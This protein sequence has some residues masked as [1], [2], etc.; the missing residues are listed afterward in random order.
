MRNVALFEETTFRV[1]LKHGVSISWAFTRNT[2]MNKLLQRQIRTILGQDFA[3]DEKMR[4]FLNS[5][6]ETYEFYEDDRKLLE[7][8]MEISSME[9]TEANETLRAQS[10]HQQQ[11]LDRIKNTI[12][13]IR[14]EQLHQKDLE[15]Y[16]SD[17][18][19]DL[20]DFLH[21]LVSELKRN[22]ALLRTKEQ[23]MNEAQRMAQFG[24]WNYNYQTGELKWSLQ[25]FSMMGRDPKLGVPS[26]ENAFSSLYG[27]SDELFKLKIERAR[28]AGESSF[29]HRI[30]RADGNIRWFESHL[31]MEKDEDN[32]PVALF[33]TSVDITD[34]VHAQQKLS[35]KI[36]E[37]EE[38]NRSLDTIIDTLPIM[39]FIKEA[40]SRQFIR[41]NDEACQFYGL[42]RE[43]MVGKNGSEIF[44]E[45]MNEQIVQ[46]D[47]ATIESGELL[48]DEEFHFN[49][50]R[51]GRRYLSTRKVPIRDNMGN[52]KF[53]MALTEDI[54]ERREYEQTMQKARETAEEAN[55]SK[56]V[57]LSNMSHELRTPLNA[58]IGYAQILQKDT[59]IPA[60][61]REYVETMYRSG[62]HLL[63]MIN[64]VLD[65]SKTE[66]GNIDLLREH[67]NLCDITNDLSVMF[68]L[69]CAEKNLTFDTYIDK[70]LQKAYIGDQ[71]R[72]QQILINLVSN[73][74]KFTNK[75]RISICIKGSDEQEKT[76]NTIQTLTF[77]VT[78][79][80]RGIPP[81]QL[82]DIFDPFTQVK[83]IFNEG[84]G[85]GL[86]IAGKLASIMD[87]Q[88]KVESTPGEGT[89]FW[90]SIPLIKPGHQLIG[91]DD[92][93]HLYRTLKDDK[94]C[95][96]LIVDDI[97]SNR[98]VVK[99]LLE[100]AGFTCYEANNGT[101][102]IEL[103]RQIH[104]D[105]IL[106]DIMM[107]K[108]DGFETTEIIRHE[109]SS[110]N[111]PI[112]A[113]TARNAGLHD[114]DDERMNIFDGVVYKPFKEHWLFHEI[115]DVTG[116]SF[117]YETV[118]L[119]EYRTSD[120][121]PSNLSDMADAIQTLPNG[122]AD[123]IRYH[124]QIQD[125]DALIDYCHTN[126]DQSHISN[127]NELLQMARKQR[128]TYFMDLEDELERVY[129]D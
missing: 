83:G 109:M 93:R 63:A 28:E 13:S 119:S 22:E 88:L 65:L 42:K 33:G 106:M 7:R 115:E 77:T 8:A 107:P 30:I 53:I 3:P 5:I 90:F 27:N 60:K 110:R 75:G 74:V 38:T 92:N 76:A 67:F 35:E 56:S 59:E 105:L 48:Q 25:I 2:I 62:N 20:A 84:T 118:E 120:N 57:F 87:G 32:N 85:L 91:E 12:N 94:E 82:K 58:I 104:P 54:T 121:T 17:D 86:S 125:F 24:N 11:I 14:G 49:H 69:K 117:S 43:E 4:Q 111:I 37:L 50:P 10:R 68:K 124:V 64:D 6:D 81:E 102:A 108:L 9:L 26:L 100:S 101:L 31:S 71:R 1:P 61:K 16:G 23:Q 112:I 89:R 45:A 116:L 39:L 44:P 129:E 113:I 73:A 98:S 47:N 96:V 79:T 70:Q 99:I 122:T 41:V 19:A 29:E 128:F 114:E 123:K 126:L 66:S 78:D 103:A 97:D 18:I 51:L 40:D 95:S 55:R 72:I 127:L 21:S 46:Q 34:R 52:I 80:G 36:S 15:D